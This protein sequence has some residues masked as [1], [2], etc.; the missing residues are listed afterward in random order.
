MTTLWNQLLRSDLPPDLFADMAFAVFGLGDTAYEKFCWPAKKLSRRLEGLGAREVC[1]R[2]EG[3]EQHQLGCACSR[4]CPWWWVADWVFRIDGALEPWI[5][6]LLDALLNMYPLSPPLELIPA[7]QLPPPRVKF[8]RASLGDLDG[9][10]E[11]LELADNYYLAT[12]GRNSRITSQDWFQDV[13]HLE[14]DFVD[15][16]QSVSSR[17]CLLHIFHT[18]H[19]HSGT[20]PGMLR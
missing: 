10:P 11:P 18:S 5:T 19:P 7:G 2:G 15:D 3:D 4:F 8:R 6:Q 20:S 13:R 9:A 1:P 14:F 17:S 12:V 16:I